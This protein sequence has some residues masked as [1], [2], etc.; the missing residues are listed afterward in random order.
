MALSFRTKLLVS[1]VALVAFVVVIASFELNR[2]LGADLLG[3]L[4][5]RLAAQADG[6]ALWMGSGRHPNR[7][8][9]RLAG[10]VHAEVALIDRDGAVLGYAEPH[11]APPSAGAGAGAPD[12]QPPGMPRQDEQPEVKAARAA[13]RGYATRGRQGPGADAPP[14]E[15]MRYVAVTT[16]EGLVLRLGVPLA[17]IEATLGA[18]RQRLLFAAALAIAAAVVLG[19]AASRVLARPLRAMAGAAR[20]IAS[21]DYAARVDAPSPDELGALAA[22]LASMAEQLSARIGDLT[23]ERDRLSV[24]LAQVRRL[25]G[26]RRDFV[27]NVSHELRTPVTAIQGCAETLLSAP[28]DAA[29]RER[30]LA[31]IHRHALRLGR[32]LSDLLRLSAIEAQAPESAVREPVRLRAIA[33]HAAQTVEERRAAK[34]ATIAVEVPDDAI[35]LGDPAGLEQVLENLVDNALKYGPSG[36]RVRV[37]GERLGDR[38][39]AIVEDTGPGIPAEHLPRVFERF[40]RVDPARSREE[41][42]AGL[43][44]AIVKHLVELMHGSVTVESEVGKG[45]RFVVTLPAAP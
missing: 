42:G 6:A 16:G 3:Q 10:V 4:D 40:Y 24:L 38:V 37:S 35:A 34:G 28:A 45:T 23:A 33:A 12:E 29:T 43:G 9:R 17:G 22:A 32:L 41:G 11:A 25:E 7:I 27:A 36:V 19:L 44:L 20:A 5:A 21:G 13:G 26:V 2:S 39:C 18:M 1:H 8:A 14:G 31:I 30:F 15:A